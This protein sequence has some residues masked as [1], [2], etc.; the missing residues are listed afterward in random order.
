M[1]HH[2]MRDLFD[3]EPRF[4]GPRRPRRRARLVLWI[5][6]GSFAALLVGA[7]VVVVVV[8]AAGQLT[9][10]VHRIP[11]VFSGLNPSSR[12]SVPAGYQHSVTIL[13]AGSDYRTTGSG[14]DTSFAPGSQRSDVL[15]L[16]HIDSDGQHV[17]VVSI[18]RDSWVPVP[19]HGMMKINAALSLGGPSLMIKTV[20]NLTGVRI[21]HY[22]VLDFGGFQTIVQVLGGVQVTIAAAT[23][24]GG[25]NFHRGVN[26]LDPAQALAYV[27]QRYG[28]PGGDLSRIQRQ[29]NL[30]RAVL[31]KVASEHLVSD[32]MAAYRLLSSVHDVL[33]V[34][35]TFSDS[36]LASLALQMSRLSSG[37]FTYLTAPVRGFGT[38]QGQDVVY[39]NQQDCAT[40]WTAISHDAVAIWAKANPTA[41]TPAVPN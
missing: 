23:S 22:A 21:D 31:A 14:P 37:S 39:L 15:M 38:E 11:G 2:S 36:D 3:R 40:L 28:L 17:S 10:N 16:V 8:V 4:P 34:D 7:V 6:G 29:Q 30:I 33:S 35:S 9:S 25:V 18:P 26:N 13:V 20:E 24:E 41:V 27:R 19:G 12:P 1:S 32:P 5:A